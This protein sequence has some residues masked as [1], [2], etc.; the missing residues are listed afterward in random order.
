ME[1][2]TK[3][4]S[5][6]L[7][8]LSEQNFQRTLASY[9]LWLEIEQTYFPQTTPNLIF[10]AIWEGRAGGSRYPINPVSPLVL[11]FINSAE[12]DSVLASHCPGLRNRFCKNLVKKFFELN[13]RGGLDYRWSEFYPDVN[14]IAHCVNLGY[15]SEDAI[16]NHILQSLSPPRMLHHQ[17]AALCILFKIAGATF[18]AYVDPSLVDRCFALFRGYEW[19]T[20]ME[21][22]EKQ[23]AQVSEP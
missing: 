13:L 19:F 1:N 14:L 4:L 15:I 3:G 5:A 20:Y 10:N 11:R 9:R 8:D 22:Y 6:A 2:I 17:A 21:K 23:L 12:S 18:D 16:R 7:Y